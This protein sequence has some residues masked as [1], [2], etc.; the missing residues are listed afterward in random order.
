MCSYKDYGLLL[1]EMHVL[2]KLAKKLFPGDIEREFLE[3]MNELG[4]ISIG[5]ERQLKVLERIRWAYGK[6]L[7][8]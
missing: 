7:S 6:R 2:E 1:S 8:H 3:D 5:I 4:D